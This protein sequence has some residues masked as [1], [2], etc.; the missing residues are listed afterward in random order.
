MIRFISRRLSDPLV[1]AEVGVY[2]GDN[3]VDILQV[4][5]SL[6]KLYLIDPYTGDYWLYNPN[7]GKTIPPAKEKALKKLAIFENRIEWIFECFEAYLIPEKLDFV[8]IDTC[9]HYDCI[10]H[11][12]IEAEKITKK[13]GIIGGHD[14]YPTGIYETRFGVGR[15]VRERYGKKLRHRE[16]DWWITYE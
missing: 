15:A 14:Y 11:D 3:A 16:T 6:K 13:G 7:Y 5:P 12:I 4:L 8:Y 9:H 2:E 10:K 1:G